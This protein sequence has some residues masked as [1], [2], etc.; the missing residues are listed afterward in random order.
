MSEQ[1]SL[2]TEIE[3]VGAKIADGF[4]DETVLSSDVRAWME[5]FG[6]EKATDPKT[7]I[8]NLAVFN[9]L[10]KSTLYRSYR[11]EGESL[12]PLLSDSDM[13]AKFA[14]AREL[15]DDRAFHESPLDSIINEVDC[16]ILDS[17][18]ELRDAVER[19]ESPTDDIGEVFENLV[20][21]SV[22]R[23][24]GQFRTPTFVG[25]FLAKWAV[26]SGDDV[27]LDPGIGAGV[28]TSCVYDAKQEAAEEGRVD[29]MWGVDISE[30]AIVMA[31]TGL[32]LEDGSG[33]PNFRHCDF[34]DTL[35]DGGIARID[36]REPVTIPT[37]D[38]V[39]SN[40]PYSRSAALEKDR[41]RYNDIVASEA[42]VSMWGQ[43]PLFAYFFVH[44]EQF[45]DDGGRLAF[46]TSSRFFDTVY[47]EDL[48]DFLLD[49]FSIDAF[50]FLAEEAVFKGADVT[51]C[52]TLLEKDSESQC[53]DTAFIRVDEW[54]DEDSVIYEVIDNG[55]VG[56]TGFGFINRIKQGSLD[57]ENNWR[58]YTNPEE[59][60]DI[61]GLSRFGDIATIKRGIATGKNDYFCLNQAEVNEW[62]LNRQ[63]LSKILRR[64]NGFDALEITTDDWEDWRDNGDEVWLLYCY[65]EDGSG[66]EISEDSL[67]RYLKHGRE[68]GA[69]ESYLAQ[70]RQPWYLVDERDPP[71]IIATYMS[72]DGF[73]FIHNKAEI[74][75]LNNLHNISL[76]NFDP[77][78]TKA[79]LAYLN[80]SVADE[81]VK[82]SGRMYARGLHKIE[83]NELKDVP[84]IDTRK[85][86]KGETDRLVAAFAA[87]RDAT[88]TEGGNV[89][90]ALMELDD[91]VRQTLGLEKNRAD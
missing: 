5:D 31:S 89:D 63:Y 65:D 83:P 53:R 16:E 85:L 33:S 12:D 50:L 87:L 4:D 55:T 67:E 79:L 24:R 76:P 77:A 57:V 27:V 18:L 56:D 86:T 39:I 46:I 84:V 22:R 20:E 37:V 1:L 62:G 81:I 44:A 6:L 91:R 59:I 60:R 41:E 90:Q 14:D 38:A 47:G 68:T 40:P 43:A 72:K 74:R 19:L 11:L 58:K 13:T 52:I 88:R 48:L 26:T 69:D 70:N 54:P 64:T 28:L 34:M 32:K 49:R 23:K 2:I 9:C 8:C 29:E 25:E 51:P 10:L 80:S 17:L 73:R 78:E 30:L 15:T 36:Q 7:T 3:S 42:G 35:V 82:E 75:T 45:L 71:D 66:N 61:P 21:Q